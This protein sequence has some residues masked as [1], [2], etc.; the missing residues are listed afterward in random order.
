M[1]RLRR[2]IPGLLLGLAI[3]LTGT[4]FA[5]TSSDK[6]KDE[7]CCKASSYCGDSCSMKSGAMKNHAT[8]SDKHECCCGDSCA[9]KKNGATKSGAT[10][11]NNECCCCGD[12]CDM[13]DMKMK[14]MKDMKNKS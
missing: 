2:L 1:N 9:T 3:A 12:S 10:S 14:D 13:K 4:A 7:C 8:V 6:A 11:D 5:Q